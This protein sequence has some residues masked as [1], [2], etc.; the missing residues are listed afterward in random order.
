MFRTI[1]CLEPWNGNH[2]Q[3]DTGLGNRLIHWSAIYYISTLYDNCKIIVEEKYWPELQFLDLPNTEAVNIDSEYIKSNYIPLYSQDIE[4]IINGDKK[5]IFDNNSSPYYSD[6]F[7]C[8]EDRILS[9]G[10]SKIKFKNKRVNKFFEDN[11]SDFCSIHL[12]RG[13]GTNPTLGFIK[14]FLFH[15]SKE[16]LKKY[17][18]EYYFNFGYCPPSS[19]YSII[20]DSVYF[21]LIDEII[22]NNK[23]QKFYISSDIPESYYSYYFDRYPNNIKKKEEYFKEF[24]SFFEYDDDI[25]ELYSYFGV[26]WKEA[27]ANL[28]DLFILSHSQTILVDN[29]STWAIVA[30]I[31]SKKKNKIINVVAHTLARDSISI[32]EFIKKYSYFEVTSIREKNNKMV[33]SLRSG[34]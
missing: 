4:D 7:I 8:S 15:K 32:D 5:N 9:V 19:H 10:I 23:S 3:K 29:Y 28:F 24:L 12:R 13:V 14:D 31:M 27:L 1:F 17:L 2:I 18:R 6:K 26:L 25:C 33:D 11:F 21:S 22:S 30:P 34:H 20:P 16:E